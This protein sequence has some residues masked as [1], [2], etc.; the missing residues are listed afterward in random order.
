M[1]AHNNCSMTLH[2]QIEK[3]LEPVE[4]QEENECK[5]SGDASPK[6][7]CT[8]FLGYTSNLIS[9]GVRESIRYL[10][11]HKMVHVHPYVTGHIKNKASLSV[12]LS[13]CIRWMWLW[14]RLEASRRISSSVWLTHTWGILICLAGSSARR[15]SIGG[16]LLKQHNLHIH[17]LRAMQVRMSVLK[18][19]CILDEY[20]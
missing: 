16:Q 2:R 6:S 19:H 4:E 12:C 13:L 8:I 20:C 7:G 10:A 11:E 15:A 17:I 18:W 1:I 9:S 5:Q 14:P 3:R